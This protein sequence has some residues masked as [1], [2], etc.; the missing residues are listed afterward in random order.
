MKNL[1]V[2]LIPEHDIVELERVPSNMDS[3]R[4]LRM[5]AYYCPN[6]RVMAVGGNCV[7][8]WKLMLSTKEV[9][10]ANPEMEW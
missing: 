5:L 4:A 1:R 2:K 8:A 6:C 10:E 9:R 7:P 3:I